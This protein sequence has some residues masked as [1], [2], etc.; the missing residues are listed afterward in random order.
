M[1]IGWWGVESVGPWF[2]AACEPGWSRVTSPCIR[3][4]P[5]WRRAVTVHAFCLYTTLVNLPQCITPRTISAS[6][7]YVAALSRCE[8]AMTKH[9]PSTQS[10]PQI[11]VYWVLHRMLLKVRC[12]CD[13][14]NLE[15]RQ[16]VTLWLWSPLHGNADTQESLTPRGH[17]PN[18]QPKYWPAFAWEDF[19]SW[20]SIKRI[21]A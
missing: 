20:G 15:V 8:D 6:A 5:G 9:P 19:R 1:V 3:R 11:W 12:E 10:G 18:V 4:A 2:V 13:D 21:G 7:L 16:S 14:Y 17:S